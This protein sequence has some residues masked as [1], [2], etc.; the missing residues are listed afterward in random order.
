MY[1][2]DLRAATKEYIKEKGFEQAM[3]DLGKMI[4]GIARDFQEERI[5]GEPN[6]DPP[7]LGDSKYKYCFPFLK[8]ELD[9]GKI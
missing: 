5:K 1:Y 2:C 4:S 8:G 6:V 3:I 9:E 7:Q